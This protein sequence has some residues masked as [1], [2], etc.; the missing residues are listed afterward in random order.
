MDSRKKKAVR[1]KT[2]ARAKAYH[3][4]DLAM[5]LVDAAEGVLTERGVE[6][7]TLRECARRAGVS[8]AAPAHHFRDTK[9][10]L[11]EVAALGFERLT[12]AERKARDEESDPKNRLLG[13]GIGYV[14]FA[15]SH[16]AQFQLMFQKALIDH[17]NARF[18]AASRAAF[19]VFIQTYM[20]VYRVTFPPDMN[21]DSDPS[22]LREWS[23]VH[24][25]ATLAVQGQLGATQSDTDIQK[26]MVF[27]RAVFED[28]QKYGSHA[29]IAQA[30]Q[31]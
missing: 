3:H 30:R 17:S 25:Y 23:L 15:L 22:V 21:K 6:G 29:Q 11:T 31:E 19:E 24:G 9:G 28:A 12:E 4:G 20:E 7:F 14:R 8:H 2:P 10:L 5:A 16:P 18:M 1:R 13:T 27:T 26:L